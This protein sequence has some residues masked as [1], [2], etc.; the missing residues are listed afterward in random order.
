MYQYR[1]AAVPRNPQAGPRGR[2]RSHLA[3]QQRRAIAF[4]RYKDPRATRRS[5]L[6]AG[7]P[8]AVLTPAARTAQEASLEAGRGR[9]MDFSLERFLRDY[10][11][12]ISVEEGRALNRYAADC[13]GGP[14]VEIGSFRG[15]SAVALADGATRAGVQAFCIEPHSAF[16]G[17][18]GGRFGPDDRGAFYRIMLETG[19]FQTVA[20]VN[21]ES[22]NAARAWKGPI[23]L[24]F[25]D[26]DH[27]L[28]GVQED[29]D[30]WENY[31]CVGGV[32]AFDDALDPQIGPS[33]VIE[34]V[35]SSGRFAQLETVGKVV[36]LRKIRNRTSDRL[37]G[38]RKRILVAS[39]A[40]ILAG[41][42]LRF[43]RFGR[44]ARARGHKVAFLPLAIT[45]RFEWVTEFPIVNLDEA[46]LR[47]WDATMVP[48]AGFPAETIELFSRLTRPN[49]GVRV[50][51]V[52]NDQT[53]RTNFLKVNASFKPHIVVFNNRHWE[54]GSFIDFQASRFHFL[55][56]AVDTATFFPD[57]YKSTGAQA[58]RFV[59]GGLANK[60]PEPL[61]E[62]ARRLGNEV[63][64][65][66]FGKSDGLGETAADLVRAGTLK[67]MGPLADRELAGF[68]RDL[69][70]VVHTETFAGWANLG[71]EALASGIPLICTR[72]GTLAFAEPD[73]TALVMAE[74][75][76]EQIMSAVAQLRAEEALARKLSSNGRRAI[77][78]FSWETYTTE[79]LKLINEDYEQV[80]HAWA[81]EL[82]LYGKWPVPISSR[83]LKLALD[84][85]ERAC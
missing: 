12:G 33:K 4:Q 76:A 28:Q 19:F 68:Y 45:P 7:K 9:A 46:L 15:K 5:Q 36:F 48:G 25:I 18:Y 2:Y 70:C 26:G 65:R 16:T 62:A 54:P 21:L 85:R 31:V 47:N 41:G 82:D 71:A 55:V 43:E 50:Q 84:R 10:K 39:D 64:V 74:P 52:L 3:V 20:L 57:R 61:I 37:A 51:H 29:V 27:S 53:L 30:A 75:T 13:I 83:G 8:A 32:I 56:G 73:V 1:W 34:Q 17:V 77:M 80:H 44:V 69:D 23:G 81:P 38:D 42:L 78:P 72:H 60:N 79:L 14:I 11:G 35:V 59:I 67:L 49:F 22:R 58:N 40:L 66:L 6:R 63:E 24:L